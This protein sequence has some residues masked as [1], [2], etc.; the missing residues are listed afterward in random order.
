MEQREKLSERAQIR[1]T[2][3]EKEEVLKLAE[4]QGQNISSFIR[5]AIIYYINYL[6]N[7]EKIDNSVE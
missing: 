1:L 2:L 7:S 4:T 5:N 6:K 3:T